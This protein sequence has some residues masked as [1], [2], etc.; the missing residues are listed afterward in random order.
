MALAI[1]PFLGL[2]CC[3]SIADRMPIDC[4]LLALSI[5]DRYGPGPGPCARPSLRSPSAD[6]PRAPRE[7]SPAAPIGPRPISIGNR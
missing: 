4:L 1:D 7:D 6:G 5:A 3:P 2:C